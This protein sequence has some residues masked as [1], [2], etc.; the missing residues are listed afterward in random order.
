MCIAVNVDLG[1]ALAT[2]RRHAI[3]SA[4]IASAC[5]P[6]VEL[7]GLPTHLHSYEEAEPPREETS[8]EIRRRHLDEQAW[9]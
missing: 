6:S 5:A 7:P 4:I 2:E 1:T 3:T 9:F 8:A